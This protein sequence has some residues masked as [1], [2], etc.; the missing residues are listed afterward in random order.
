MKNNRVVTTVTSSVSFDKEMFAFMEERRQ[1]LRLD[2]SQ[3]LRELIEQEYERCR[4]APLPGLGGPASNDNKRNGVAL[5]P[6]KLGA[7]SA[8]LEIVNQLREETA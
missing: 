6:K 1:Q 8:T 2:R 5:F 7:T 3:F 4:N